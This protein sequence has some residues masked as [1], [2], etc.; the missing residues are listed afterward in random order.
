MGTV[1]GAQTDDVKRKRSTYASANQAWRGWI[2][3]PVKLGLD[4]IYPPRCLSCEAKVTDNGNFC[5]SC[6]PNIEF[7]R[8]LSCDKCGVPLPGDK[9][10]GPAL[11]DECLRTARPWSRGRA[12][13]VYGDESRRIVLGLK[14]AD[15]HDI[16][17]A[18][19]PWLANASKDLIRRDTLIA[20]VPLHPLRLLKRRYNQSALLAQQLA[21]HIGAP[22]C[23]DL[24]RRT[25]MTGVQDSRTKLG[26][27][28]NQQDAVRAR[29]RHARKI[30][31][32]HIL[33]VDDVMT[34]GA[35]LAACTEAC[36]LAGADDVDVVTLARVTLDPPTRV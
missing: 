25:R 30:E 22:C 35:T 33:L 20:P 32:K 4:L 8:D 1:F 11:C 16:A 14:Y 10:D 18:A 2:A 3:L 9:D 7:I 23:P 13:M 34:S 28:I 15:R 17:V 36:F 12:A 31:G 21:R 27:F 5:A 26:R 29:P 6:W 24:L 19:G